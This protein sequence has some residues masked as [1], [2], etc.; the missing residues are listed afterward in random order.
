[1]EVQ[2]V[3]EM[4]RESE[5]KYGVRYKYY[6]GDGD[7]ASYSTVA[8]AQPYGPDFIIEKKECIGHVQKRMGT[9]L[10]KLKK[11]MGNTKLSDD[12]TIGGKGRLT[13]EAINE[14]QLYYGLAIRRNVDSLEKM[15]TA[16]WAEYFHLISTNE[17]PAHSL[18]PK[19]A[20][21]W[22]KY[23][24]AVQKNELYDHNKHFHIAPVVMEEIKQIF[25]D[26][27]DPRLLVK[28]LHGQTQNPSESLNSV[29]WS[30]IPKT[31]LVMK[32]TLEF[33]V[34]EAI[35][36][37]N[38]GNI[39]KCEVLKKLGIVPGKNCVEVMKRFDNIRIRKAQ[40]AVDEVEK[41]IR[42]KREAAKRRLEDIHD[43]QE[44]PDNPAYGAG[45]H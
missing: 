22:C 11:N 34:Y 27:A 9:R 23:Q 29:V 3:L 7:S 1:M 16:V 25:R 40:K 43:Q 41:K 31:T 14:I 6:L 39:I 4:F 17:E 15:K 30:R 26:L 24:Q 12:K 18:C 42:Q 28:C 10:R 5:A 2:G 38:K 20:D 44:D 21:T 33:G 8:N 13:L 35:A 45:M 32:G 37:F 36:C 19:T